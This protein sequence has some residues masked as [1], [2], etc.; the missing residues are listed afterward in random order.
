MSKTIVGLGELLWDLLPSGERL[1]GAPANFTVMA[2]RLGNRG[3]IASRLG[4]DD[5]GDRARAILG[6]LPADVSFVQ[7]DASHP[8]GTVGV[9]IIDGEPHYVIHEPV[10]WDCLEWTPEWQRLATEADAVCF[11]TLAQRA[12]GSRATIR[13]F[14]TATRPECVRVFD[15]NLR[16]PFFSPEVIAESLAVATIFKLNEVEV[17]QVLGMLGSYLPEGDGEDFLRASA[18]WLL[19]QYPMR[20]VAITMGADGSL[21]VTREDAHRRGGIH[22]GIV[23]TVGAGDAFTAAL[24]DSY[25]RG[26]SLA[27]MNEAGNRW[28]GWVASQPGAMPELDE[29]TLADIQAKIASA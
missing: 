21:L 5:W 7:T 10:A 2:S 26:A 15:V 9:K 8:T 25:L 24:V 18:S 27:R 19:S 4:V 23:D 13:Q 16:A 3:V 17:P 29:A 6:G 28:G 12:N 1:G 11:G 20:V 14:L 22:G